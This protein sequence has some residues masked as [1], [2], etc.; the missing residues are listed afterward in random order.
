VILEANDHVGGLATSFT[1]E[2][3]LTYDV[4]GHVSRRRCGARAEREAGTA[5]GRSPCAAR[6]RF[7]VI[8]AAFLLPE[9]HERS[10]DQEIRSS[11][12]A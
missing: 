8:L 4:G 2:N 7:F 11:S 10:Q 12:A 6:L 3:G 5:S 9:R 1:S